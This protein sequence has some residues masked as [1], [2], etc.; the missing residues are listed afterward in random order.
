MSQVR[1]NSLV[2]VGGIPAGAS[3]G[4]IIQVVQTVKTDT[5]SESLAANTNSS[6][7]CIEVTITPR[8]TSNKILVV[9]NLHGSS[10][11]WAPS[12]AGSWQGRI[13]R[14]GTDIVRG[15]AAGSRNRMTMRAGAYAVAVAEGMHFMYLDSPSSTS[16]L[17]YGVRLDNVDNGSATMYLNRSPTD[18]DSSTSFCRMASSITVLEVSG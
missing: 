17:T 2:P 11:Y 1:T 13:V 7:N 8:S 16:A 9:C 5:F 3:G 15:D 10:S 4:G 12:S 18:T 14:N 6:T